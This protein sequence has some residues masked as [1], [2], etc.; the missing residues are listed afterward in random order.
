MDFLLLGGGSLIVL[1][2]LAL[3]YP[4]QERPVVI[5]AFSLMLAHVINHPHFAHS[6]QLSYKDYVRKLT[7][8]TLPPRFAFAISS[9]ESS[10]RFS[11]RP[12][13]HRDRRT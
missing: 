4:G 10:F 13:Y 12:I 9:P 5:A 7:S 1:P 6:Y 2:L 11:W 8:P 3:A